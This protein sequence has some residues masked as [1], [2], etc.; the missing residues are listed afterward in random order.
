MIEESRKQWFQEWQHYN[1]LK[2]QI[3]HLEKFIALQRIVE[4]CKPCCQ[5][6]FQ[7]RLW[8]DNYGQSEFEEAWKQMRNGKACSSTHGDCTGD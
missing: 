5:K 4:D 2:S 8:R 6:A 3:K 1:D 7:Q